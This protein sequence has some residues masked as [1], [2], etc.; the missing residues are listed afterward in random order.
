M[1]LVLDVVTCLRE[2]DI[3]AFLGGA[4]VDVCDEHG[5]E[6]RRAFLEFLGGALG[7]ATR[8]SDGG[9]V[10]V[11][12]AVADTV[13]PG[14][15][16]GVFASLDSLWDFEVES[17]GIGGVRAAG[18]VAVD[19]GRAA[20][21]E[22]LDD[23]PLRGLGGLQVGGQTDLTGTTAVGGAADESQRVRLADGDDC[24]GLGGL[25]GV[26][27]KLA[28][29]VAAVCCQR[30]VVESVLAIR[31]GAAHDHVGVD[32]GGTHQGSDHFGGDEHLG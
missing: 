8:D 3:D 12:L 29:E 28:R 15:G 17:V 5:W 16:E 13:E 10:H 32:H 2:A 21:L 9:A 22:R 26:V 23:L 30:R 20:T 1:A 6:A 7:G 27:A 4:A 11:H 14:P 18:H 31:G 19:I 25:E 24:L